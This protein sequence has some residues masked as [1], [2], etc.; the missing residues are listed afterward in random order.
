MKKF[1]LLS[2]VGITLIVLTPAG[3]ARGGGAM[4]DLVEEDTSE[5]VEASTAVEGGDE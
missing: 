1:T 4:A 5:A 2:L 3:W